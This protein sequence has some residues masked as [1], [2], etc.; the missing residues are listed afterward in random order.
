[1]EE[2]SMINMPTLDEKITGGNN[3]RGRGDGE[4]E[5]EIIHEGGRRLEKRP[6]GIFLGD[7]VSGGGDDDII[8]AGD[9]GGGG[10]G[11]VKTGDEEDK[12][13]D[14]GVGGDG[15]IIGAFFSNI[16]HHNNHNHNDNGISANGDEE[17]KSDDDHLLTNEAEEKTECRLGGDE[18]EDIGGPED[19]NEEK[20]GE[21]KDDAADKDPKGGSTTSKV[22]KPDD[23]SER[24]FFLNNN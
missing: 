5:A 19:L 16:F 20:L 7:R 24:V 10:D 13:E 1:M 21:K 12:S 23:Y 18:P 17:T 9:E 15:G 11:E 8:I 4:E 14:L 6:S 2:D 3:K 22:L